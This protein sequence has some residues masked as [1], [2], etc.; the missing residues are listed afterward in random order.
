MFAQRV[1]H[2]LL[3]PL[4]GASL[5][6]GALE[7]QHPDASTARLVGRATRAIE[8]SRDLVHAIFN[9]ARAG[10]QP[11][12]DARAPLRATLETAVEMTVAGLADPPQVVIEPFEECEVSCETPVLACI[13]SNLVSNAV[14]FTKGSP[15]R[16]ITLRAKIEATR[17]RV[18]VEDTGPGIS[19]GAADSLFEPYVRGRDATQPGLGLGLATVKR[20]VVAYGGLVGVRS[21]AG[22]LFWFELPRAP[23]RVSGEAMPEPPPADAWM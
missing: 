13:V 1:A 2:D 22:A 19:P 17:A 15:V 12:P 4:T 16:R 20:F 7:R 23:R 14:K 8:R 6:L 3:S 11:S 21:G 5:A 10:A 18:E 9:F